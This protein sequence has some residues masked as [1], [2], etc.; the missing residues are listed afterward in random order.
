[1]IVTDKSRKELIEL[2]KYFLDSLNK[3]GEEEISQLYVKF[4]ESIIFSQKAIAF[5]FCKLAITIE[6]VIECIIEDN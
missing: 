3:L 4:S 2:A 1:M 5:I 6:K